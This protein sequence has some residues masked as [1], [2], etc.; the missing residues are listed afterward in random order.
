MTLSRSLSQTRSLI[1][2]LNVCK[3]KWSTIFINIFH[4]Y[5]LDNLMSING[6][7]GGY[8]TERKG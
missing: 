8:C 1:L 5:I 7:G 2:N 4:K 6:I 3:L